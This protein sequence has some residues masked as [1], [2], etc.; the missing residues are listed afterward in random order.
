M[1]VGEYMI[2]LALRLVLIEPEQAANNE[3]LM[4]ADISAHCRRETPRWLTFL[5]KVTD[6]NSTQTKNLLRTSGQTA[7]LC[8]SGES[9]FYSRN[10]RGIR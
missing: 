4:S 8:A 2:A 9:R 7:L 1:P 5:F 6:D 10:W 3:S